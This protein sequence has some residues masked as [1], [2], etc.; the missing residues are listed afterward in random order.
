MCI[1][2]NCI[3][4]FYYYFEMIFLL[5]FQPF[6]NVKTILSLWQY[7]NELW[8]GFGLEWAPS[9]LRPEDKAS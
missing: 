5:V 3:F 7:R 4:T 6:K 1:M 8:V 9:S 2:F